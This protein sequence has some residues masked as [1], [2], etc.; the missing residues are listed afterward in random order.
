MKV[1]IS[2]FG[3]HG[4]V[5]PFLALSQGLLAHGHTVAVCTS[6]SYRGLGPEPIPQRKLSASSLAAAIHTAATDPAMRQ[7][8]TAIG[9]QIRAEDGVGNAV[10]I[11]ERV[12]QQ[13]G[14]PLPVA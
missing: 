1:L 13:H 6:A 3:T 4:D 9:E 10:A 11:L 5:Q 12:G 14:T 7:R 2:T 8:A